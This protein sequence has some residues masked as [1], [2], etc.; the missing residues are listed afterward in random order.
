MYKIYPAD[1]PHASTHTRPARIFHL[2]VQSSIPHSESIAIS[3]SLMPSEVSMRRIVVNCATTGSQLHRVSRF[4]V[5]N[6]LL[7]EQGP[8][9]QTLKWQL[10]EP[11][12]K[13]NG[14]IKLPTTSPQC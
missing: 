2:A 5:R 10:E 9:V 8:H 1:M 3:S 13:L 6:K 12:L 11:C 7:R 14:S 4:A